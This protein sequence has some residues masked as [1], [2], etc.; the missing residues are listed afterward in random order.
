MPGP[1]VYID[2][3]EIRT[4]RLDELKRSM[5]ELAQFVDA[6]EPQLLSYGFFIEE[7]ASRMTV[8]AVHPD[9]ASLELHMEIGGP[10]FRGFAELLEML[11]IDIYGEP[12]D[13]AL[14][15]LHAK[16]RMLGKDGRVTVHRLHAGFTRFHT[17]PEGM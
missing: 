1:I 16:A 12:S 13:K 4:E 2:R 3:S 5:D 9:A 15:Q 10:R 11:S 6:E 17:A 7:G 14:E 8:V